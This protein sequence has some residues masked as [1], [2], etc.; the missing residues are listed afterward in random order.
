M[1]KQKKYDGSKDLQLDFGNVT[2]KQK[3][4]LEATT[5]FVCYGGA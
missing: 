2:P 4:F 5:F 3:L 1:A